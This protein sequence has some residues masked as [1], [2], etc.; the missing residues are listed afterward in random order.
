MVR[1]T[2]EQITFVIKTFHE[3]N[4]L[5]QTQVDF[6][7]INF[8]QLIMYFNSQRWKNVIS[9]SNFNLTSMWLFRIVTL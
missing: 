7:L 1:L 4:S 2:T 6:G 3:T 5:Q 9:T 8:A